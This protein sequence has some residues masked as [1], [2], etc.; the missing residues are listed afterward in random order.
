M[1]TRC[2]WVL[3]HLTQTRTLAWEWCHQVF[4][5]Q[6]NHNNPPWADSK[7]RLLEDSKVLTLTLAI[8]VAG[9]DLELLALLHHLPITG[10]TGKRITPGL[11]WDVDGAQ[12]FLCATQAL[13]PVGQ[14]P[15]P[16]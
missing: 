11:C 10:M 8:T 13:D 5:I 4:E 9:N 12:D 2:C 7:A 14:T 15:A 6:F 1:N 16:S 3:F